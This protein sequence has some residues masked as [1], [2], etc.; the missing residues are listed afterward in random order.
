MTNAVLS[1]EETATINAY[2][3]IA[4]E[5]DALQEP[6]WK[7]TY[8]YHFLSLLKGDM[9]LDIGCGTAGDAP[10]FLSDGLNYVGI[11]LSHNMLDVARKNFTDYLIA[12]VNPIMH[13]F[14][15][16]MH[17][18]GFRKHSIDGFWAVTSFMHIAKEA[19]PHVLSALKAVI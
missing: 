19:L 14:Q 2:D 5:W 13:V 16:N 11:D 10:L 7:D 17:E 8:Y 9:I 6:Q 4:K 18:F 1:V 12:D 3:A 15:M